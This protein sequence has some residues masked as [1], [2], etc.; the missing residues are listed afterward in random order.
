MERERYEPAVKAHMEALGIP[1]H[2]Q[3]KVKLPESILD[4]LYFTQS[5]LLAAVASCSPATDAKMLEEANQFAE[6]NKL[7]LLVK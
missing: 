2:M 6:K 3:R 4:L 7:I 5:D 1:R